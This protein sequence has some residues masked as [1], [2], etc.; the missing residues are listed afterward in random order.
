MPDMNFES[1]KSVVAAKSGLSR[2]QAGQAIIAL[3]EHLQASLGSGDKIRL[4][5]LGQFEIAECAAHQRRNPQT[6]ETIA[7][8]ASKDVKFKASEAL[9]DTINV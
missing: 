3:I 6:G 4:P 9:K 1:L 5:G 2:A 8:P 7:I